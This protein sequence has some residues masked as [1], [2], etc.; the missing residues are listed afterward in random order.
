MKCTERLCGNGKLDPGEECDYH[1][2]T[3]Y[4]K[5][6]CGK[7]CKL[8]PPCRSGEQRNACGDCP[9]EARMA[10]PACGNGR[11]E[12]GES[13]SNCPEDCCKNE[14]K[15]DT[16]TDLATWEQYEYVHASRTW[17]KSNLCPPITI[18]CH[19]ARKGFDYCF[20][21]IFSRLLTKKV[22]C[23]EKP[24]NTVRNTVD[25][26][27]QEWNARSLKWLPEATVIPSYNKEASSTAC[28][29]KCAD[30]YTRDAGAQIC[31]A[32]GAETTGKNC[33]TL[34]VNA[35]WTSNGSTGT[36]TITQTKQS[37]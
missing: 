21:I 30:G 34:P 33:T 27:V 13:P 20:D 10:C 26:Y 16:A 22:V 9:E 15:V 24:A 4:G 17:A 8:T 7:N 25:S 23:G 35:V 32:A 29:Y 2:S 11:C 18:D 6:T 36:K 3:R 14:L 31:K 1:H 19:K 5:G 12:S 28:R 37:D